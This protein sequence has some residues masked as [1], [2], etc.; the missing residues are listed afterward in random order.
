MIEE[1]ILIIE[2]EVF[3][4]IFIIQKQT[5]FVIEAQGILIFDDQKVVLIILV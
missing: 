4:D 1:K 5:Q 2:N 3:V